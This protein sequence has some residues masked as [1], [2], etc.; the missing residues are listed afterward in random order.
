MEVKMWFHHLIFSLDSQINYDPVSLGFTFLHL[1]S[2]FERGKA[3]IFYAE[4]LLFICCILLDY[5]YF[6]NQQPLQ[7]VPWKECLKSYFEI[8]ALLSSFSVPSEF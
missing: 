7:L 5:L 3:V 2:M 6:F 1:A 8:K 4:H